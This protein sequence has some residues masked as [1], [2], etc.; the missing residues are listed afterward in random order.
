MFYSQNKL[1]LNIVMKIYKIFYLMGILFKIKK[2]YE[3]IYMVCFI[4]QT[5]VK[6]ILL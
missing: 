1:I 3:K 2:L 4:E 6:Q 5:I